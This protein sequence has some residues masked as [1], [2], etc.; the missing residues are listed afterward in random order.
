MDSY[1]IQKEIVSR[2]QLYEITFEKIFFGYFVFVIRFFIQK[3]HKEKKSMSFLAST[4]SITATS[5]TTTTGRS[6]LLLVN[7][8]F[9]SFFENNPNLN[10]IFYGI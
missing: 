3:V 9:V 10:L 1:I 2:V 5:V 6:P 7:E 8:R 4:T